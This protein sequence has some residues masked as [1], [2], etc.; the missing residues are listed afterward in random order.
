M[1]VKRINEILVKCLGNPSEHRS[2]TIDVWRPVCLNIQAVSEHQDELVDLLKEWPD[3]SWGQPVPALGEE[4]SYITVGAVLGSQQM[5]FVLFA[6]G[7]MLGWWRLLTPETVLGLGK[8]NPYANQLVGLG[9][10][11]VTGYA[12]GD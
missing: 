12:P 4:L 5:A 6:V 8:A 9:F 7:L 1:N 3:E 10:I 11:A 2:H